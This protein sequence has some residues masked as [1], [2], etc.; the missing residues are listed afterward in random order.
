MIQNTFEKVLQAVLLILLEEHIMEY[1]GDN[2]FGFRKGSSVEIATT[3]LLQNLIRGRKNQQAM[4]SI[5][6]NGAFDHINNIDL[7]NRIK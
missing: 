7:I 5:D 2:Q 1:V 3:S 4:I 6:I